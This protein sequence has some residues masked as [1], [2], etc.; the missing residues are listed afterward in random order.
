MTQVPERPT[1]LTSV[2]LDRAF[3]SAERRAFLDRLLQ[4]HIDELNALGDRLRY[5]Q[6]QT[7]VESAEE[8]LRVRERC[9]EILAA[10]RWNRD[11]FLI[12]VRER[13]SRPIEMPE[14]AFGPGVILW[15]LDSESA[16]LRAW[17]VRLSEESRRA[18]VALDGS[19]ETLWDRTVKEKADGCEKID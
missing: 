5:Y 2:V 3:S 4:W 8:L 17:A 6:E 9:W 15:S 11:E 1:A 19:M 12:E 16:D 13:L 10:L 7:G 14:D 18:L